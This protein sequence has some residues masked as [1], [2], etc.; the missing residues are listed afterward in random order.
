LS[1][2]QETGSNATGRPSH[3]NI[4]SAENDDTHDKTTE[5]ELMDPITT[6]SSNEEGLVFAL[7]V[8]DSPL[9]FGNSNGPDEKRLRTNNDV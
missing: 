4:N 7:C 2:Q 5:E 3:T 8:D 1:P 6:S 9:E